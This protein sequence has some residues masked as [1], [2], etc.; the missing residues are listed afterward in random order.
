M[1]RRKNAEIPAQQAATA[2]LLRGIRAKLEA[3][4]DPEYFEFIATVI[5]SR[6]RVIGV[7]VPAIRAEAKSFLAAHRELSVEAVI[8]LMGQAASRG[9]RE[10][11]L[12]CTFVLTKFRRKFPAELLDHV[13]T[14]I[15]AIDNW[16]TCDQL[17]MNVAADLVARDI[18]EVD[19]LESW[20]QSENQWRRRFA[21]ATSAALNQKGR[22]FP[23]ETLRVCSH[24]LNDPEPQVRKAVGWAIREA[25]E[26]DEAAAFRFLRE[27]RKATH[28]TVLREASEKLTADQREIL[29]GAPQPGRRAKPKA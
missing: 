26:L 11:M 14:W 10:E 22:Q 17:A 21:L 19:R 25:S 12:F 13:D 6:E 1:S 4:R 16:E 9:V 7:R 20:A 15:E 24:V 3:K 29:L 8:S 5:G 27:H 18:A 23:K 28:P 2:P